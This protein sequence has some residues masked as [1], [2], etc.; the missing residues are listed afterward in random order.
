MKGKIYIDI[1]EVDSVVFSSTFIFVTR[2]A[3]TEGKVRTIPRAQQGR[4][5]PNTIS[6]KGKKLTREI[7]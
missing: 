3:I 6:T 1:F 4:G 2:G 5:V 7:E